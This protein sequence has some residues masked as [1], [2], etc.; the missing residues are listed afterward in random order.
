[1]A[2]RTPQSELVR[3]LEDAVAM[4]QAVIR[5]L[6]DMLSTTDDPEL[7]ETFERHVSES[8]RQE[9]RLRGRLEAHGE[10]GESRL[11]ELA[12]QLGA[13]VKGALDVSRDTSTARN[14]RD[15]YVSE[16][17]E[18]VSYELLERVARMAGDEDTADVARRNRAE[19]QAMADAILATLDRVAV[20]GMR[21]DG[22]L[23]G[24]A[25][26]RPNPLGVATGS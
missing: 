12:G 11:K 21:E 8:E 26:E 6:Q 13:L 23:L 7:R 16:H 24:G 2:I 22:A 14:A 20:V 3:H 25:T 9:A 15:A 17:M 10:G 1:L 4:E 18:I 19:E 5:M